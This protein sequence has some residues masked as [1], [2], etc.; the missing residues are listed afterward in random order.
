[1]KRFLTLLTAILAICMTA[2][3]Q[4]FITK[5]DGTEIQAKVLEINPD[6]VK[7]V[8]FEE[9]EGPVSPSSRMKF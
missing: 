5:K 1:M 6:N 4:D 2:S 7:Y 9:T 8:L 3:A